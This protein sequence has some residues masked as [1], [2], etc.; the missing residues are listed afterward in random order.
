MS[1][2]RKKVPAEDRT[3]IY[4]MYVMED[5]QDMRHKPDCGKEPLEQQGMP[6]M[7]PMAGTPMCPMMQQC[8]MMAQQMVMPHTMPG[9]MTGHTPGVVAGYMPG[10]MPGYTPGLMSMEADCWDDDEIEDI[11]LKHWDSEDEDSD[12]S[13]SCSDDAPYQKE[14]IQYPI[15]EPYYMKKKQ[16]KKSSKH[17]RYWEDEE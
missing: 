8:P 14:F 13:C 10:I 11:Q 1:D 2:E 17:K 3:G 15:A 12:D 7:C 6:S 4:E 9:S 5:I 16:K